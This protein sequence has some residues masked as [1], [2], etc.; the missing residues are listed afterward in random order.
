MYDLVLPWPLKNSISNLSH[1]LNKFLV[2]LYWGV[3]LLSLKVKDED[4]LRELNNVMLL[5]SD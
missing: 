3:S 2:N 4:I 5:E 1:L